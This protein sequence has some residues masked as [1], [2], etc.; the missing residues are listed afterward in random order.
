MRLADDRDEEAI[1]VLINVAFRKAEGFLIDRDRVDRHL[2][3]SLLQTGNFLVAEE[4]GALLG[5]AYIELRGER[6]YLG[7]LSVDPARQKAGMGS[8]LMIAAED[9][10]AKAGCGY[11]DIQVINLRQELPGFYHR[12]GY[13]DTGTAPLPPHVKPKTPCHFIKM[14]KPLAGGLNR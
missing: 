3:Q 10:A 9:Y 11:M 14:S 6:A 7:L 2:M 13:T 12:L 5:C 8:A 4:D 1:T